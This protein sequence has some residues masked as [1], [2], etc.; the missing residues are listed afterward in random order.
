[1]WSVC[2]KRSRE[3]TYFPSY[4]RERLSLLLDEL[5][6]YDVVCLQEA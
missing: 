1:M 4:R 2:R 3:N 6:N 5:L